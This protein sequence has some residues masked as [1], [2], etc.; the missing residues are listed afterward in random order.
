[1]RAPRDRRLN[2]FHWDDEGQKINYV[3]PKG[4]EVLLRQILH[5]VNINLYNF[6][7]ST[8]T[9][10]IFID[11]YFPTNPVC[12][13]FLNFKPIMLHHELDSPYEVILLHFT[14]K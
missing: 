4:W 8:P 13:W 1:M 2:K 14:Q 9:P 7:L 3:L 11:I 10:I 5:H 6:V 12:P